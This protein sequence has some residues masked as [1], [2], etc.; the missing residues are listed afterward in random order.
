MLERQWEQQQ[1]SSE[2]ARVI[3]TGIVFVTPLLPALFMRNC[4]AD[5]RECRWITT[6][7]LGLSCK[8]QTSLIGHDI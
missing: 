7:E 5:V 6:G 3:K 1:Q 4:K 2:G 8:C